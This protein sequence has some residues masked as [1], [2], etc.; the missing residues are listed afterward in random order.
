M[1]ILCFQ[2]WG[3]IVRHPPPAAQQC[4]GSTFWSLPEKLRG[5]GLHNGKAVL[6]EALEPS[7]RP[8]PLPTGTARGDGCKRR[9][10]L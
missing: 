5:S 3:S 6:E 1:H 8:Q 4:Q 10:R 7:R 9:A 2:R